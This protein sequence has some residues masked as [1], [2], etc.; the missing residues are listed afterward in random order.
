MQ[1]GFLV[2]DT[3]CYNFFI[4]SLTLSMAVFKSSVLRPEI[5]IPSLVFDKMEIAP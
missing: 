1:N 4:C 5:S 3:G 2:E